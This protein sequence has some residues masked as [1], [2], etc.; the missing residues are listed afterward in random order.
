VELIG[1]SPAAQ[2]SSEANQTLRSILWQWLNCNEGPPYLVWILRHK[3]SNSRPKWSTLK[4]SDRA[5]AAHLRECVQR[6]QDEAKRVRVTTSEEE[7]QRE[8]RKEEEAQLPLAEW[9][10]PALCLRLGHVEQYEWWS[11]DELEGDELEGDEL[12]GDESE[13]DELN[14]Y[15]LSFIDGAEGG[16]GASPLPSLDFLSYHYTLSSYDNQFGG[17]DDEE[18]KK[19]SARILRAGALLLW[20]TDAD[21]FTHCYDPVARAWSETVLTLANDEPSTSLRQRCLSVA[22]GLLHHRSR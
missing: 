7:A 11:E 10:P 19:W 17:D 13:E 2:V 15:A 8:T 5:V 21:A 20:R 14:K 18:S 6:L 4:G 9:R 3:Y 1:K 16:I 12:E 22:H